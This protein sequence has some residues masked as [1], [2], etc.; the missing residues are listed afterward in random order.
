M[1]GSM[2]LIGSESTHEENTTVPA[3]EFDGVRLTMSR[4]EIVT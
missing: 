3:S 1:T 2:V 4:T